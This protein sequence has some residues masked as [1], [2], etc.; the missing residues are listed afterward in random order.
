LEYVE[1]VGDSEQIK[2]HLRGKGIPKDQLTLEMFVTMM[3]GKS[4]KIEMQR[5]FKRIHVN[6]NSKQEHVENF[7]ILKLDSL[8]KRIN[9][10]PWKGRHFIGNCSVPFN[11]SSIN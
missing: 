9:S 2:Y 1:K 7:S 3:A 5:N 11:H 4:I 10:V 6:K 8:G